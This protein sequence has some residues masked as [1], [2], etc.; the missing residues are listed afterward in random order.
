MCL[1]INV[2]P[3]SSSLI[4]CLSKIA[5]L[6]TLTRPSVRSD[7]RAIVVNSL[8][9]HVRLLTKSKRPLQS[10]SVDLLPVPGKLGALDFISKPSMF[11]DLCG[12]LKKYL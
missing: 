5:L 8:F 1:I 9:L 3:V 7:S 2:Y 4:G 11:S 10:G 6:D 12:A